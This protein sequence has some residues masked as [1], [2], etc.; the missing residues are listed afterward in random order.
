MKEQLCYNDTVL[1][2]FFIVWWPTP[3]NCGRFLLSRYW[4]NNV[5]CHIHTGW[6]YCLLALEDKELAIVHLSIWQD[7]NLHVSLRKLIH[8]DE[9]CLHVFFHQIRKRLFGQWPSVN[10]ECLVGDRSEIFT[11]LQRELFSVM[12]NYMVSKQFCLYINLIHIMYLKFCISDVISVPA[13]SEMQ[14]SLVVKVTVCLWMHSLTLLLWNII[15][16]WWKLSLQ[17]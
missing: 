3:G 17:S 7:T 1:F 14:Y 6:Y 11:P 9:G 10:K 12:N 5:Y 13:I 15:E 8:E 4:A 16:G 2:G